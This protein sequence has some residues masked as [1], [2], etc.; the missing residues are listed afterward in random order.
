MKVITGRNINHIW[1][2]AKV[3]LNEYHVHRPSRVGD[4]WECTD[5]VTTVYERPWERVLFDHVRNANP[6]FHLMEALWML[7][8]RNDV[9]FLEKYNSRISD[10]V[11]KEPHLHDAYGYRWRRAFDLDGGAED[12]YADQLKKIIRMLKKNPD[13][14]RAVLTMW[15]P[16]WDL[17]RPELPSVPCNLVVTFKVRQQKLDM[18]VFCRS[19]DI[20]MGAY[21]ANV[22][23]FSLL[24]EYMAQMMGYQIGRYWQVSDSWHAYV[25]NWEIYGGLK[26]DNFVDPYYQEYCHVLPLVSNIETFD[27][28]LQIFMNGDFNSPFLYRNKFFVEVA[29]P[30]A[31]AYDRY[32]TNGPQEALK[33]FVETDDSVIDWLLS[34]KVW[35]KRIIAKREEKAK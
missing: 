12:D 31:I 13:E 2:Q 33:L 20:V 32:Q 34:G 5:P 1:P 10:Y 6:F 25:K 23:H 28:D 26:I 30:M 4:V 8:G 17:E 24:Q 11:G 3:L 22:V 29:V 16:L 7:A 35:L 18:I 14:R 19:N 27:E 21:G 15:N 9:A